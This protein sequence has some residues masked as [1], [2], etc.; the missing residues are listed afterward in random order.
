MAID[1]QCV[2]VN[3]AQCA[4]EIDAKCANVEKIAVRNMW[5]KEFMERYDQRDA[6]LFYL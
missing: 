4:T 2:A 5:I 1:A 6:K 3:D